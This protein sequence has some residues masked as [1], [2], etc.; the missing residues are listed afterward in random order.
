[1]VVFF[2]DNG[3]L[4]SRFDKIPLLALSKQYLYEGDTLL[5]VASSNAPLRAEKGTVYEGGIRE[6]L[7]AHWPGRIEGGQLSDALITSVDFYPTFAELAGVPLPQSQEF[8]G[9][10]LI[11]LLEGKKANPERAVF[12]H[13]PVYHHDY[14]AS[15]IR[16]G[17]W[18]L[19]H[20]LHNDSLSLYNLAED[21]GEGKN[22]RQTLPEKVDEL[23][24]LLDQ[25][26]MDVGATYPKVNPDFDPDRRKE[27]ARHPDWGVRFP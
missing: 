15:A 9:N 13:Y 4:V 20:H 16:K 14:P 3:G 17:D 26:R 23:F 6:P 27:W 12:W 25:W 5:Y 22:L 24:G 10:S 11:P 21:I 2:S 7:I 18:K 1:M 8:D 19:I